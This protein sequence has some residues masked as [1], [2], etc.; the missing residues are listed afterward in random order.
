MASK[1]E[2]KKECEKYDWCKGLR[3]KENAYGFHGSCRLLTND[4]SV[5]MEGWTFFNKGNWVEPEN[6][7]P[8]VGQQPK[9]AS[10]KCYVKIS[11][12]NEI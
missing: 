1:D 6:W 10:Y 9:H 11:S 7:L 12:G 5:N 3:V 2:C 4:D 8:V